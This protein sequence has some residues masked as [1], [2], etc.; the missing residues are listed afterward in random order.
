MP[1]IPLSKAQLL[2]QLKLRPAAN[3]A[4]VEIT[5][6]H[7]PVPP[8]PGVRIFPEPVKGT[9]IKRV[10]ARAQRRCWLPQVDESKLAGFLPEHLALNPHQPLMDKRS[11]VASSSIR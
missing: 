11:N 3:E 2:R 1:Q 9:F 6:E 7:L 8:R 5:F 10:A 4:R